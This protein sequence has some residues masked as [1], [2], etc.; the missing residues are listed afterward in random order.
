MRNLI[1]D[2]LYFTPKFIFR[3][4]PI[5]FHRLVSKSGQILQPR[6]GDRFVPSRR[7]HITPIDIRLL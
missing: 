3:R 6:R 7:Q 5:M 1:P 2:M 4:D